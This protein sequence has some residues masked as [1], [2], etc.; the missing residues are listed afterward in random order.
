MSY[1]LMGLRDEKGWEP[2]L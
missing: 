1:F 2:L